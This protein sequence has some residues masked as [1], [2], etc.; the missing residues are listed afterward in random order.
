M[1]KIIISIILSI[2]VIISS[3]ALDFRGFMSLDYYGLIDPETVYDTERLRLTIAPELSSQEKESWFTFCLSGMF[4]YQPVG[5]PVIPDF[6]R[7]VREAYVGFHVSFADIYLGQKFVHRGKVDVLSPLDIIN[8]SDSTVLS[9]DDIFESTLPD[10]LCQVDIY[11]SDSFHMEAV[12]VPFLSPT[13]YSISDVAITEYQEFTILSTTYIYDVDAAFKDKKIPMFSQWAHSIHTSAHYSSDLFDLIL[14][15]SNYVDQLPDFD[16]SELT[17]DINTVG[18]TQTHNITGTAYPSFNRVN[19]IG[20]GTSF[21]FF[22]FLISA[23][24]ALKLTEDPDGTLLGIRNNE[25][26]SVLQVEWTPVSF[27]RTQCNVFNRVIFDSDVDIESDYSSV[28]ESQIINIVDD[29]TLQK[30]PLQLYLLLHIDMLFLRDT[31]TIGGNFLYGKED[32]ENAFYFAP[33]IAYSI[34]DYFSITGGANLWW[35]G[36][37]EGF[38]GR[39]ETHDNFF[40]RA[41]FSI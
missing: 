9:M 40:V 7:L 37:I 14:T 18:S 11:P 27:L 15:Y 30:T 5:E 32:E 31:L 23:D 22:D 1:K 12:Y 39:N 25:L 6:E 19:Q 2:I 36:I 21:Y 13:I 20:M 26:F 29:Y 35:G 28:I 24:T 33:R 8:H 10:L 41:K 38:L 3:E 17:E 16:L 34:N 4:F